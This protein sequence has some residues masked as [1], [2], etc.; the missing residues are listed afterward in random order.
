MSSILKALKKLES[1]KSQRDE[2]STAVASDILKSSRQTARNPILL[3]ILFCLFVT[4]VAAAG[5]Y[6]A[7][8]T[9]RTATVDQMAEAAVQVVVSNKQVQNP[10]ALASQAAKHPEIDLPILS[11]IVY[12]D[13]PES[14]IAIIN[15]LPVM[16]G[17][18]VEGYEVRMISPDRVLLRKDS[19]VYTLLLEKE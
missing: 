7:V 18:L 4:A 16:E 15:D 8:V 14:R 11:G 5:Y 12:Q 17:T 19:S 3:I 9:N 6:A 1:E 2:L 10:A 13:D